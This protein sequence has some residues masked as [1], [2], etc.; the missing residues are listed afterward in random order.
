[1][2]KLNAPLRRD[3]DYFTYYRNGNSLD[4]PLSNPDIRSP[5]AD[6]LDMVTGFSIDTMHSVLGGGLRRRLFGIS[7]LKHEGKLSYTKLCQIDAMLKLFEECVPVEFD[8]FVRSL[9]R[10]VTKYKD[11]ELRQMLYYLLFSV[12][13]N[14]LQDDHLA[15]LML[16][17]QGMLLL[18]GLTHNPFWN[19]ILKKRPGCLNFMFRCKLILN[20]LSV[21]PNIV[22]SMYQKMLQSMG[23]VLNVL[24]R[25]FLRISKIFSRH[26]GV[27]NKPT[28][29]IRNRLVER[30]KY[31][32]PT[33]NDG[34]LIT[35]SQESEKQ[36]ELEKKTAQLILLSSS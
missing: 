12:F 28:E 17:R 14:I 22:S 15:Q 26:L 19:K 23:V 8:R 10:C 35:T 34:L 20:I 2:L 30:S 5:L 13:C 21:S 24:V 3:E 7:S 27:G 25:L 32:L 1:M 16:L 31:C 6:Y 4:D 11:H 33:T 36:A 9:M 18:G 29:Q